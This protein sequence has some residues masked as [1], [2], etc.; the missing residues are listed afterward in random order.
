MDGTS[1]S[2]AERAEQHVVL[3]RHLAE[4]L[5]LLEQAHA[6]RLTTENQPNSDASMTTRRSASNTL[7]VTNFFNKAS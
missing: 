6:V 4:E 2:T 5:A 1:R 7:P 3:H